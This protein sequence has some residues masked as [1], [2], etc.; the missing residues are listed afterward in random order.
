MIDLLK[1]SL[2]QKVKDTRRQMLYKKDPGLQL[3]S[4]GELNW[5]QLYISEPITLI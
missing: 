3:T 4:S 1:G 5:K 2:A